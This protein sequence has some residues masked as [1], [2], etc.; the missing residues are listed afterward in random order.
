MFVDD[1]VYGGLDVP[2]FVSIVEHPLFVL[3]AQSYAIACIL[4]VAR[5][6]DKMVLLVAVS[7]HEVGPVGE[8]TVLVFIIPARAVVSPCG[9]E[10]GVGECPCG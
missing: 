8:V 9:L 6:V 3:V 7:G 5:D 10:I 1:I 4:G 2:A